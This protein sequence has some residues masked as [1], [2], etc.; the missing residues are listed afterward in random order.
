MMLR[1]TQVILRN[2]VTKDLSVG[3]DKILR[4]RSG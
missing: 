4:I 2:E 1:Q 3:M